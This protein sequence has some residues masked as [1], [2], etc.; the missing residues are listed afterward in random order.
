MINEVPLEPKA[1]GSEVRISWRGDGE[2]VAVY[3]V[4]KCD[5]I[6]KVRIFNHDLE[7]YAVGRQVGE[8]NAATLK[9]SLK[10]SCLGLHHPPV[11][12]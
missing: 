12:F 6:S 4:D 10:N 11:K 8:G 9:G 7:L 2:Y 3:T 1:D 5:G